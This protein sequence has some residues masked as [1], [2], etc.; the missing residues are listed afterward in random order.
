MAP[1]A[2]N[3]FIPPLQSVSRLSPEFKELP[4]FP[5]PGRI[6]TR[7]PVKL[8]WHHSK[9]TSVILTGT[10]DGWSRSIRLPRDPKCHDEFSITLL[11]DRTKQWEFK[12][13]V[14]GE[15]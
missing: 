7:L 13:V 6:A 9:A 11:L 10:F 3:T 14:D 1:Y 8:T 2:S 15:W 12:F 4:L 5:L